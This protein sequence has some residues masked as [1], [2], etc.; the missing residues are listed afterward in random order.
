MNEAF[1]YAADNRAKF[2]TSF[3]SVTIKENVNRTLTSKQN[4]IYDYFE[5]SSNKNWYVD[6]DYQTIY[7][8][9]LL[10]KDSTIYS[11]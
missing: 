4:S 7:T 9:T 6:S 10:S 11:K 5:P 2:N 1:K 8:R 3:P